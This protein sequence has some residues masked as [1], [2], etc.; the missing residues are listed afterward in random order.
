MLPSIV[1]G[2]CDGFAGPL[3]HCNTREVTPSTVLPSGLYETTHLLGLPDPG[4]ADVHAGDLPVLLPTETVLAV[5]EYKM[6]P[7]FPAPFILLMRIVVCL[8]GRNPPPI[9]PP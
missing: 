5:L 7:L 1:A 6:T 4:L 2:T 8:P 3:G 9:P